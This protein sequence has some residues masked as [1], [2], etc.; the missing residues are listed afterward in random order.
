MKTSDWDMRKIKC[1]CYEVRVNKYKGSWYMLFYRDD[2]KLGEIT[3]LD[4][5]RSEAHGLQLLAQFLE[6]K[7]F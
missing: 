5:P 3:R 2:R 6:N 1:G 7:I 4:P